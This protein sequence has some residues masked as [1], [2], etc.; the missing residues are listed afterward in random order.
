MVGRRYPLSRFVIEVLAFL[1]SSANIMSGLSSR[2]SLE[3]Y[4][5]QERQEPE[6]TLH[7]HE[8]TKHFV[9]LL[10]YWKLH[11]HH[12]ILNSILYIF[13][14]HKAKGS[15]RSEVLRYIRYIIYT[16]VLQ[17]PNFYLVLKNGPV[18]GCPAA[19]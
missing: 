12:S 6:V 10:K 4:V 18:F 15:S 3:M 13:R 19:P 16:R 17:I 5:L 14:C 8:W 7:R 2:N 9:D 11:Y 1:H